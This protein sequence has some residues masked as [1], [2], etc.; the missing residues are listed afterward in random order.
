[1]QSPLLVVYFNLSLSISTHIFVTQHL[2]PFPPA[3]VAFPTFLFRP[4]LSKAR[5]ARLLIGM[6]P[7]P[8]FAG[9][10]AA[11]GFNL[12]HKNLSS[13]SPVRGRIGIIH[14]LENNWFMN[15]EQSDPDLQEISIVSRSLRVSSTFDVPQI[16]TTASSLVGHHTTIRL[17]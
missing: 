5:T 6:N 7:D 1:M 8:A 15:K 12:S 9:L 2:R 17:S 4:P 3:C 13:V 11:C 14:L 10:Q 16:L